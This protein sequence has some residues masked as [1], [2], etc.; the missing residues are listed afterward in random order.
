M[1]PQP[2]Y[3]PPFSEQ[4]DMFRTGISPHFYGL[5]ESQITL[6]LV[7]FCRMVVPISEMIDLRRVLWKLGFGSSGFV[8]WVEV[9]NEGQRFTT[10]FLPWHDN[11][12][13]DGVQLS[14]KF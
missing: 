13:P 8:E 5:L 3:Q 11:L 6:H 2:Q 12:V 1:F 9:R 4:I 7:L 10:T 14:R